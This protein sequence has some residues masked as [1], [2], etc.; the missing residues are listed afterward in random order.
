MSMVQIAEA[1]SKVSTEQKARLAYVYIRQS[2][3]GQVTHHKESTDLQYQLVTR[4]EQLGWPKGRVKLIDEDLGKSGVTATE[5]E[6]FQYLLAEIGLGRVGLVLSFDASRLAR[7]NSDWYRLLELCGLFGSLIADSE[8]VYDP[9]IF[10]DRMLLGLSGMMS[11]AEVY[12]IKR[13]MHAGAWNKAKRGELR[14]PLPVGLLRLPTTEVIL[15]PDEEIQARLRL[16]LDKFDELKS[17]RAVRRYLRQQEFLLPS[18]PLRGPAPHEVFWRPARTSMVLGIL[19]NPAYAGVYVHGRQ[20]TDPSRRRPSHPKSGIVSRPIDQWPIVIH[21]VYPAYITWEKFLANRTQ[22]SNNRNDYEGDRPGAPRKGQALLQGIVKCGRCGAR[23]RLGYSGPHG[24]FP[25]YK[26]EY[27]L[28]EYGGPRCQEVRGLGLDAEVERLLLKALEP[29]QISLAM[30]ALGELDKE[31]A[32][33]KQQRELHLQRLSYETERAHRQYDAVEP[34]N[35]LVARTL[36]NAW[37]KKLRFQEK[38]EQ[39]HQLWL[40]QQRLDLTA[41]D[42]E[43]ILALGAD[44]PKVWHAR[45]TTAADRK[46]ILRFAIKEVIVDQKRTQGKVWFKIVW[47]TGALSEHWYIRRVCSYNEHAHIE[48]IHRRIRELHAEEKLDDEI[49]HH[50]NAEGLCT[51]GKQPFNH[52]AIWNLRQ[53][54]G[55]PPV[56]PNGTLPNRWEDGAYSVRGA[57]EAIGV[58]T[59]TIHKWLRTGRIY[60]KQPRKRTPWKIILNGKDIRDLQDYVQ[61][62]RRS[63]KEAP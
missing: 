29:D 4:A 47:Q 12:Q 25:V 20:T 43:Q 37:E 48:Q 10:T 50:L 17:A 26:C 27:A 1:H 9:N 15:N 61:R 56:K 18:R 6:G 44:L 5:R 54:M 23:M 60:G 62:V 52:N 32:V 19:K 58:T 63:N 35:R 22:L 49:A 24:Q 8:R 3:L 21:N 28:A 39:E 59:G 55:L 30:A 42:R 7:N 16:V 11:E 13:R 51:T 14:Q 38:A 41:A 2:S 31:H 33:L 46:Q 53:R 57:S 40:N 36:E 34:E 45:S